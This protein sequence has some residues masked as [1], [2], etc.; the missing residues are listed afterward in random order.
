MKK[1]ATAAKREYEK[2]VEGQEML[3][4]W[5]WVW[6]YERLGDWFPMRV[7]LALIFLIIALVTLHFV[8]HAYYAI[9]AGTLKVAS[10]ANGFTCRIL[11]L[12]L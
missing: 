9:E 3:D 12:G 2:E 10:L 5:D 4:K 11:S 7:F 8:F 1:G 6:G